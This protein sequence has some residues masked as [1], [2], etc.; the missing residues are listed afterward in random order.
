MIELDFQ[1][2]IGSGVNVG[3]PLGGRNP[4]EKNVLEFGSLV[5]DE[6]HLEVRGRLSF[7]YWFNLPHMS[8]CL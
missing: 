4:L 2:L 6:N 7:N 1:I 3:E 8:V 5:G